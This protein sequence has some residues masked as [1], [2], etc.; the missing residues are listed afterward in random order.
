M[1]DGVS[2]IADTSTR[3]YVQAKKQRAENVQIE[4]V[5]EN[6]VTAYEDKHRQF[7]EESEKV[8]EVDG[9][10]AGLMKDL[11]EALCGSDTDIMTDDDIMSD[12]EIAAMT[13]GDTEELMEK[14]APR[15]PA[16]LCCDPAL[17]HS[18]RQWPVTHLCMGL[19]S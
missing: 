5:V 14:C 4:G 17:L 15:I 6:V 3:A 18:T 8:K 9:K 13:Q 1:P 2:G 11:E 7:T 19:M 12:E 10:V 16:A